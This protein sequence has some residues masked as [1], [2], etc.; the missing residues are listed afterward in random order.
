MVA[1]SADLS[2]NFGCSLGEI[3]ERHAL[4]TFSPRAT[5][6]CVGTPMFRTQ[7]A[8][9]LACVLDTDHAVSAWS[10][11]P[12]ML[13]DGHRW[14]VPDFNVTRAAG[15]ALTDSLPAPAWIA[16]AAAKA[17]YVYEPASVLD[18]VGSRVRNSKDLLAY[19]GLPV[20]LADRVRLLSFLDEFG[21][22]PLESC[23]QQVRNSIGIVASLV[24]D[25]VLDMDLDEAPIGPETR[26]RRFHA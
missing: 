19:A 25:R 22:M 12:V 9:D 17:G 2:E 23:M 6:R 21:P 13:R 18:P 10:C 8:R 1:F 26:V 24:L 14:H 20:S 11:L 3:H 7:S 5:V 15:T 4:H 16:T